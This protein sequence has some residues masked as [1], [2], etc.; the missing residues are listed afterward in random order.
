MQVEENRGFA[1][2]DSSRSVIVFPP[3]RMY[4]AHQQLWCGDRLVPLKPKA[5][6]ILQCLLEQPGSLIGKRELLERLWGEVHLS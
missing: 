5:F 4:P 1:E 2:A 6:A 3:F